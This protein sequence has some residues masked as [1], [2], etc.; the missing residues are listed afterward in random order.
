[1]PVFSHVH[2]EKLLEFFSEIAVVAKA[3]KIRDILIENLFWNGTLL[4]AIDQENFFVGDF[5]ENI[6]YQASE[7][8]QLEKNTV[9][10][11][12][13]LQ[14]SGA[15]KFFN[16]NGGGKRVMFVGNSITLHGKRP[17]IG[18]NGAWG[19]AASSREK[20]Y[21]HRLMAAISEQSPDAAFCICQV[22]EWEMKYKNGKSVYHKY[23]NARNFDADIIVMRFVEN[24][25]K[26]DFDREIFQKE[27]LDL[28]QYLNP[29]G[30]T[31]I[32]LTT[33][34]WH[35]PGDEGI[36]ELARKFGLPLIEL[37]DLGEL[38]EMKAVGLF[39]HSGV[40]NHPGDRG[41]E[42]IARRIFN[43]VKQHL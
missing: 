13:Q 17:E 41:M 32:F 39:E 38:D 40:A 11:D 15:V 19:M 42:E 37:G 1:M 33:G 21:V 18:W 3:A 14:D 10:A 25:P 5:A 35:H 16:P 4:K 20:D 8:G 34:F 12:R 24:C 26:I 22:A 36:A 7:Y 2:S 28:L 30:Q 23:E 29:T 27:T 9:V 6:R 43:S 31:K